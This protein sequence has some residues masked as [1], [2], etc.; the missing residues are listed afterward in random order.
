M[1]DLKAIE[2]TLLIVTGLISR[3]VAQMSENV[4]TPD[5]EGDLSFERFDSF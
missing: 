2:E 1:Q 4:N 3:V 5:E